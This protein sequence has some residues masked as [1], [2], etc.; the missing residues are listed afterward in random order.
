MAVSLLTDSRGFGFFILLNKYAPKIL[1]RV[2][3]SMVI[4]KN[5][6]CIS[7]QNLKV[8]FYSNFKCTRVNGYLKVPNGEYFGKENS[9]FYKV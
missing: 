5:A 3:K 6:Q 1:L 4:I 8:S 2:A 7:N 9:L